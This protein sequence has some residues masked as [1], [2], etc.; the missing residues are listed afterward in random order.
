M[1]DV[2]KSTGERK[3]FNLCKACCMSTL[4]GNLFTREP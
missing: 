1:L 4:A 3:P 2:A